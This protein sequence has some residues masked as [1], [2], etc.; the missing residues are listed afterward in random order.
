V[1]WVASL[2]EVTHY[3]LLDADRWCDFNYGGGACQTTS[4]S[5]TSL[6]EHLA[7]Q[8]PMLEHYAVEGES[9]WYGVSERLRHLTKIA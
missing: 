8:F 2:S 4:F 3:M 5:A 7:G 6:M 1:Q 9:L